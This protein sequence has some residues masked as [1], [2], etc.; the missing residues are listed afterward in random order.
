[1]L[2]AG[3]MGCGDNN[4]TP[5]DTTSDMFSTED[6]GGSGGDDMD[7]PE[8]DMGSD[9]ADMDAEQDMGGENA[10]PGDMSME[11]DPCEEN[12][13]VDGGQCISCDPGTTNEAGDEPADGDTA[14]DAVIC[15]EN[16]YVEDNACVAC[17]DGTLREAGDDASG[18][19]TMCE[20]IL[21]ERNEYVDNNECTSCPGDTVNAAGDDASGP[22]TQC[23]FL[24]EED[25]H[26]VSSA[27]EVCPAGSSN[28]A[29]DDPSLEDTDCD[30][31]LCLQDEYVA[32]NTCVTCPMDSTNPAGDDPTGAD[33]ACTG[34]CQQNEYVSSGACVSCP[35]GTENGAGDDPTGADTTCEVVFCQDDEHVV[36]NAC[37]SCAPGTTNPAGDDAS[38]ADTQC[39][40]IVCQEDERVV[41]NACVACAS[42]TANPAGDDATGADT[43]C[44]PIICGENEYVSSNA[45]V[46]CAGS[47]V[48]EAGD[49][50]SGSDTTCVALCAEDEYVSSGACTAC[51]GDSTNVAGDSPIAGDTVCD[52][53][54][55]VVFGLVCED[56]YQAYIKASDA[57]DSDNF[58][59][60]VAID[61]DRLV[62]GARHEDGC[63]TGVNPASNPDGCDSSGAAYIF[64]RTNG[65]WAQTAMLK[66]S[67]P[68]AGD[69]FGGN[70][71][72]EGDILVVG[73][74][75]EDSCAA[76][77][78][79]DET[80]ELCSNA[81]AA[82]IFE[83]ANGAWS[84]TAYVKPSNMDA[85]D[86][87]GSHMAIS[88]TRVA[89]TAIYENSCSAGVGGDMSNNA[90]NSP[91]AV[92]TFEKDAN[93][94]GQEEYF[95][96]NI[97]S[98]SERYGQGIALD[99]DR[100]V[101]GA[102]RQRGCT[103]GQTS[104]C[105]NG[106]SAY[107]Y[108]YANGAWSMIVELKPSNLNGGDRFGEDVALDG[109]RVLISARND[110]SC[111]TTIDGNM[112]DN[113]C[114][115][116]GA[117]H[118]YELVNGNWTHMTFFKGSAAQDGAQFGTST[119]IDG[120]RIIIGSPNEDNCNAGLNSTP[121][122]GC[123]NT[124]AV[125]IFDYVNGAWAESA[126][127][128][129]DHPDDTDSFGSSADL[130]GDTVA[131]SSPQ[132]DSCSTGIG[133]DQADNMCVDTGAVSIY[134]LAP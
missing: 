32:S 129:S 69:Q 24:C 65:V 80:D 110:D 41:S 106:G 114:S 37:V 116:T 130:S 38:G 43:T 10:N 46:A 36:S 109:D 128:K 102:G 89:I 12:E 74:R 98:D 52:D 22:D 123:T 6:M 29:G 91:G 111:A 100:L 14:C 60:V 31:E 78:G 131:L 3:A 71:T 82:Y 96:S 50:A 94:W 103:V 119:A 57:T 76:S 121:V 48:N 33:T 64:E 39:A 8:E 122:S 5:Q 120:D 45:C 20:A 58:G 107:I 99:G 118:L 26:V 124:G 40:T 79:G 85:G 134:Q 81:G 70:L 68:G 95:K 125:Y 62:V 101:V 104:G 27:C 18:S 13:R 30:V 54:C 42:G 77:I 93:G 105:N 59:N 112:S 73:A 61:G 55:S 2:L 44:A 47:E 63:G 126:Y 108:D 16:E 23:A 51:P 4:E 132:D 75:Y 92:F 19:D 7:P 28:E 113:N 87:F 49:D 90:C 35:A 21:C 34:F 115:N 53:E 86:N 127:L 25:E 15:Q 88:G 133:G 83:Y 84:Q 11:L 9:S 56:F 97:P 117:A 17:P 72:L 1:M 67:N 66:A